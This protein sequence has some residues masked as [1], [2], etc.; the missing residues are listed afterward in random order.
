ML[1]VLVAVTIAGW[2]ATVRV[3]KQ[4]ERGVVFRLDRAQPPPRPP[5]LILLVPGVDRMTRVNVQVVTMPVP[6][7][8]AITRDNVIVRV[9]AVVYYKVIDPLSAVVAV[10]DADPVILEHP[11]AT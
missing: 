11:E 9:D 4:V 1:A 6:A 5:G 3:V 10:Q 8:D 2:L 7:Q